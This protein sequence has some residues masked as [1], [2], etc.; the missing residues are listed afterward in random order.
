MNPKPK[1]LFV[2]NSAWSMYNFRIDTFLY[3]SNYF[4]VIVLAPIDE[5]SKKITE[6]NIQFVE[7]HTIKNKSTNPFNDIQLYFEL[8]KIYT[9][10]SPALI[11]HYTIKPNIYGTLAANSVKIPCI[12]I[13]TGLGY[14]FTHQNIISKIIIQLYQFSLKKAKEVWFLNTDDF[15]TFVNKKIIDYNKAFLLYGEGINVAKYLPLENEKKTKK[16][17]F[18]LSAR[19]LFDKG[20][21]DFIDAA[22]I[23]HNKGFSIE[24]QLLGFLDAEN[25]KGIDKKTMDEWT[26]VAYI[27]YLGSTTN[28]MPFIA[29]ADC[30]VLPSFYREGIPRILME[31]ASMSKPIITT[32]NVG[33]REVVDDTINGFLCEMK[34]PIDLANKMEKFI[35]LSDAEKINMG[36]AGR[37][38][39]IQLF[40]I[41]IVNNTYLKKINQWL[42]N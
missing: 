16:T 22:T 27:Q 8:K 1:V 25:P 20:V 33:C 2:G 5:Y 42:E 4:E 28:V 31:A 36:L 11:I 17:I 19:M 18:L 6:N 13:T 12:A 26:N 23:L 10:L 38:K 32:N 7:I 3:L 29:A 14:A 37:Q 9:K 40:D 34:N 35:L 24:A 15:N 30:V 39:M 41:N 21:K